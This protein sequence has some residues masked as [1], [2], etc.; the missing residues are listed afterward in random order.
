[1]NCSQ[2]QENSN[3]KINKYDNFV[4][5]EKQLELKIIIDKESLSNLFLKRFFCILDDGRLVSALSKG[6][7]FIYDKN[8][9][10]LKLLIDTEKKIENIF[11]L[12]SCRLAINTKNKIIIIKVYENNYD[13][14]QTFNYINY[15]LDQ[16]K[17]YKLL[18]LKNNNLV[19]GLGN[20]MYNVM[21]CSEII[22]NYNEID[23]IPAHD[24]FCEHVIQTK[25]NEICFSLDKSTDK[26]KYYS[27]QLIFYDLNKK[28][29]RATLDDLFTNGSVSIFNMISKDSMIVR[30]ENHFYIIDTNQYAIKGYQEDSFKL[31]G[32]CLL[33]DNMFLTGNK[34]G[35]II[36]WKIKGNNIVIISRKTINN[37]GVFPL[38]KIKNGKIVCLIWR[39]I[40]I[41]N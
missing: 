13:I 18:E 22:N 26:N 31:F 17:V 36:Q 19:V 11:Q 3:N 32:F 33:S 21:F 1:M 30:G 5:N 38:G 20:C 41:F 12:S 23:K 14:L 29:T 35:E 4:I 27:I 2:N 28:E 25:E 9:Y 34:S 37:G 10:K 39:T 40:Y 16:T 8:T 6:K 7:I 24:S 15:S